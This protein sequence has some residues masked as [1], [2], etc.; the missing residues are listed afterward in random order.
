[1]KRRLYY[2]GFILLFCFAWAGGQELYVGAASGN[3]TPD[4]LLPVSG[5]VGTP[6]QAD[7]QK[8]ELSVR[9]MVFIQGE[10]KIA[11]AAIDNL[12][13]TSL[14]CDQVRALV[15]DIPAENIMIGAT[16]T[17]S[18][19]DA[20]GF[21]DEAGKPGADSA[22][23]QFCIN[24]MAEAILE[25][26]EKAEPAILTSA[27]GE[28]KGKI[29]YNYY[30]PDLY[31]PR[32][33]VIQAVSKTSGAVIGT[34]VNYAI[35]PEVIGNKQGIL[36]PDLCGPLYETIE[37]HSGGVAVFMNGA[38]GG[39]VTADNRLTDGKE[40][41]TWE[42][43]Q[44]IGRLLGEE[45][46][47]IIEEAEPDENPVLEIQARTVSFPVTGAIMQELMQVIPLGYEK[48]NEVFVDSRINYARI[49]SAEIVTIPGEALPNI[50]YYLKRKMNTEKAFLFGLTNDAYG[51][52][53]TK[54][55]YD[56][57]DRYDYVTRTS[58]GEMT[59]EI[60]ID[61]ILELIG[62]K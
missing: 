3:V 2:I 6:R 21:P 23:T 41:R 43:C 34:L 20:Y 52:I 25:A 9:A 4:P 35:H 59:G 12:G 28:A 10:V 39:M 27:V 62:G 48:G 38:Q 11:V 54:V 50:G 56:S 51:Y 1:M 18:A 13:W 24:R 19:P 53:L 47:R 57:F 15:P 14:L 29:S 45:A 31:D 60:L 44:R 16:H 8:G 22:Y 61:Q 36:S 17:H 5:G 46:L 49:G 30:A 42:E 58:L 7:I 33:G 37:S 55:D 26:L 40:A 32:C